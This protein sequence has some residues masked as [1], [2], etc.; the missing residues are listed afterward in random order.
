MEHDV[1]LHLVNV[2]LQVRVVEHVLRLAA[3]VE[4]PPGADDGGGDGDRDCKVDPQ[5]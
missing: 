2:L 3:T 5:L 4:P 1:L